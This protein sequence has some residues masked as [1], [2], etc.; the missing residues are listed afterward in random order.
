S[1]GDK[2]EAEEADIILFEVRGGETEEIGGRKSSLKA[3]RGQKEKERRIRE[4]GQVGRA[5]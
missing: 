2:R 1:Q 3:E 5:G 4:K